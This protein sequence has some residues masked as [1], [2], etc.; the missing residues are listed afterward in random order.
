MQEQH[1]LEVYHDDALIFKSSRH[2]LHPL[3]DLEA[4]LKTLQIASDE[5][6]VHD[7]IIGTASAFLLANLSVR[8]VHAVT[9]S[10]LGER[11]LKRFSLPYTYLHHVEIIACATE[12]SLSPEMPL[13][14]ALNII[15]QRAAASR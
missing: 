14:Q 1:S 10:S 6:V 4:H 13:D 12:K 8:E 5:L 15:R 2:W 9:L 7:K 3:L 11:V